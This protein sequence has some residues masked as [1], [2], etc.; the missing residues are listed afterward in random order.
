MILKHIYTKIGDLG[1]TLVSDSKV[2]KSSTVI[3]SL[4]DL[5]ELNAF[6]GYARAINK[7]KN[8]EREI[9]RIL[10]DIQRDI[11]IISGELSYI[12]KMSLRKNHKKKSLINIK[13]IERLEKII[14][15]IESKIQ[16]NKKFIYA[17]GSERSTLLNVIRTVTRRSERSIVVFSIYHE[18]NPY[19]LSYMNRLSS[20]FFML[21]RLVNYMDGHSEEEWGKR[22]FFTYGK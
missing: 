21:F 9:N 4:G 1:T 13:K 3:S 20:L 19:I 16:S 10:H 8:G 5:D 17:A 22:Q 15:E 12:H 2:N 18:V 7:N 11:F 14:D 6:I